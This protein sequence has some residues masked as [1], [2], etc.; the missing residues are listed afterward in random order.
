MTFSWLDRQT[1]IFPRP[2]LPRGR[3][4]PDA[5]SNH[6]PTSLMLTDLTIGSNFCQVRAGNEVSAADEG[7]IYRIQSEIW[8]QE[9]KLCLDAKTGGENLNRRR[10]EHHKRS[11]HKAGRS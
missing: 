5:T 9:Y 2:A 7:G 8:S 1:G 10:L 4:L 3:F 11:R 6:A